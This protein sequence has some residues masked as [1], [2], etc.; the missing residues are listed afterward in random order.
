MSPC[1][2][3]CLS[4]DK[5]V[6]AKN[7]SPLHIN[8]TI[9]NKID[10][11]VRNYDPKKHQRRSIR[12][13]GYDY[14]QPGLYFVTIVA[15]DRKCLF[16]DVENEKMVFNDAGKFVQNCWLDIPSHFPNVKLD[17]FIVMPNHIHGIISIIDDDKTDKSV[18]AKHFS[19]LQDNNTT[20]RSPSKT[21]GSIVRG[22]KIGVTKW[23]RSNTDIHNVWQRNYYD[24]VIRDENDL[25]HIREYI[26]NNPL[27][28]EMDNENPD[29]L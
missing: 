17:E 6:G 20:F 3:L 23:F 16:G 22:L 5:S 13:N 26:I 12:L 18:G 28:W 8:K 1:L 7:V 25:N 2:I 29:R 24:H 4:A 21:I 10:M 27:Q 14:S 11:A 19:P 15:M 9:Y